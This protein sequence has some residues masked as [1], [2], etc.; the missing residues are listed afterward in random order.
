MSEGYISV[1]GAVDKD[2][3]LEG[4]EGLVRGTASG[5]AKDQLGLEAPGGRDVPGGGDLVVDQGVVVLQVG[6]ETFLFQSSPDCG[7]SLC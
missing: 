7:G 2:T 5:L 3:L 6:A 4:A 1:L